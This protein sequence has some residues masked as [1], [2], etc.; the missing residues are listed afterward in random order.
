ME[1]ALKRSEDRSRKSEKITNLIFIA[2][3]EKVFMGTSGFRL[4][5]SDKINILS[6]TPVEPTVLSSPAS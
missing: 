6:K 1:M 4:L 3:N 5:T 2:N